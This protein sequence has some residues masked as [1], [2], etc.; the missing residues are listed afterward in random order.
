[1]DY[2]PAG[3]LHAARNGQIET[4]LHAFLTADGKNTPLSE[5]LK[6]APRCYLGPVRFPLVLLSRCLG[7]EEGMEYRV[8]LPHWQA[9][10]A[11][12]CASIARGWKPPPLLVM[13]RDDGVLS[14]RDGNN[15]YGAL[16]Q[17]GVR[18]YWTIFWFNQLTDR[19]RFEAA[20]GQHASNASLG[21]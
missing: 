1:M 5:G 15:R 14:V 8:P 9:K 2:T 17:S 4:W 13:Y 16:T 6:L 3:A 7:P 19:D 10:T 11:A 21:A 20:Y 18:D 12:M